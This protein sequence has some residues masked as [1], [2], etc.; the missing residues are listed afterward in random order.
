[1][2]ND[3]TTGISKLKKSELKN[4]LAQKLEECVQKIGEQQVQEEEPREEEPP[5]QQVEESFNLPVEKTVGSAMCRFTY[6]AMD[7]IELISKQYK[8]KE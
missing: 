7:V 5:P 1:M 6:M 3:K 4:I 2:G 8:P